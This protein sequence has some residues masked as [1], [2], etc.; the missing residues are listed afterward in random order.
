MTN[1]TLD[2]NLTYGLINMTTGGLTVQ[3]VVVSV[4][5]LMSPSYDAESWEENGFGS[6]GVYSNAPV[7]DITNLEITGYNNCGANLQSDSS[8]AFTVEG[9]NIHD[10]G[11]KGIIV[12]RFMGRTSFEN[13]PNTF[14]HC[15]ICCFVGHFLQ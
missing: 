9:L 13:D 2:G 1:V 6:M 12:A 7:I 15:H 10:V 14:R 8:T 11:R 5:P 4:D 3:D